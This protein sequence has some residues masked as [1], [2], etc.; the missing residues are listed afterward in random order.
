MN[1]RETG[2]LGLT[3]L[4]ATQIRSS[5]LPDRIFFEHDTFDLHTNPALEIVDL[6]LSNATSIG[7][8]AYTQYSS[9]SL[10]SS[11][12]RASTIAAV[13]GGETYR[14]PWGSIFN[15]IHFCGNA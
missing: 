15:Q 6:Q 10:I 3:R 8:G 4:A 13:I 7:G 2:L 12:V 9:E 1:L 14:T 5:A 11:Q